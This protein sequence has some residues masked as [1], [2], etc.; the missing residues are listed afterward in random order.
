MPKIPSIKI[1]KLKNVAGEA[2]SEAR[3]L[4][5]SVN[6]PVIVDRISTA[7]NAVPKIIRVAGTGAGAFV[8]GAYGINMG[9]DKLHEALVT[10][11]LQDKNA[12]DLMRERLDA[13]ETASEIAKNLNNPE[14]RAIYY[15]AVPYNEYG[16]NALVNAR[17]G[18][19]FNGGNTS[20]SSGS[21][22]GFLT[23]ALVLAGAVTGLYILA[24]RSEK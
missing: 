2:L 19:P 4:Y 1:S 15:G 16:N 8:L 3:G 12:S 10:V 17:N 22:T 7:K 9:A 18:I 13:S 21:M 11:G 6:T 23:T 5:Q 14:T 24:K 20:E